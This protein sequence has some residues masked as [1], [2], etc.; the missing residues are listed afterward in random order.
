MELRS[1]ISTPNYWVIWMPT[2]THG[3]FEK[4][5]LSTT[6]KK[7]NISDINNTNL[8]L[9]V[10]LQNDKNIILTYRELTKIEYKIKLKYID[11]SSNGLFLFECIC[12]TDDEVTHK[13]SENPRHISIYAIKELYHKHLFHGENFKDEECNNDYHFGVDI[14]PKTV[15]CSD[16][17]KKVITK[18]DLKADN[19]PAI[20]YYLERI[21]DRYCKC[22]KIFEQQIHSDSKHEQ[23]SANTIL[24]SKYW[25][26]VENDTT[27]EEKDKRNLK[28]IYEKIDN[29]SNIIKSIKNIF[30]NKRESLDNT[31]KR[32]N[33][34]VGE[35]LFT[36]VLCYSKYLKPEQNDTIRKLLLNIENLKKG[37]YFIRDYHRFSLDNKNVKNTTVLA[38]AG[39]VFSIVFSYLYTNYSSS[40]SNKII[41]RNQKELIQKI[42]S[43]HSYLEKNIVT[44]KN[45]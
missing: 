36:N 14:Y 39:V 12:L 24:D 15:I 1:N 11:N 30:N 19:N 41:R 5:I 6:V 35:T 32:S 17:S 40:E 33:Q 9:E 26:F 38:I 2:Y 31:L 29:S 20:E 42:D 13:I 28:E 34:V 22:I 8:A 21:E 18:P 44:S 37:L 16:G 10:V 3:N 25:K 27:I 4:K 45:P 43:I 23:K 7:N